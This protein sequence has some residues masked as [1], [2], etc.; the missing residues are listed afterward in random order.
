M[1]RKAFHL[2]NKNKHLSFLI[3]YVKI[4]CYIFL[5]PF[6]SFLVFQKKSRELRQCPIPDSFHNFKKNINAKFYI[7]VLEADHR[8]STKSSPLL[9]TWHHSNESHQ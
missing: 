8:H 5:F 6:S 9:W 3:N 1:F 2:E 4:L 7:Q